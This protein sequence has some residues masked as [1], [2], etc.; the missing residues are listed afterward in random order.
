MVPIHQATT[1]GKPWTTS[2]LQVRHPED[3]QEYTVVAEY[4]EEY[5]DQKLG[6]IRGRGGGGGNAVA[7]IGKKCGKCSKKCSFVKMV[8]ASRNPYVSQDAC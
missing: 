2:A 4:P 6:S 8:H 1:W 3:T 7:R 5:A